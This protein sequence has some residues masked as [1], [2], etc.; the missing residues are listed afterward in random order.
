MTKGEKFVVVT[1]LAI[2][3]GSII[4][5]THLALKRNRDA[6]DAQMECIDLSLQNLAQDIEIHSLKRENELLKKEMETTKEES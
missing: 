1:G 3:L 2:E 6:Y 5:L 4:G